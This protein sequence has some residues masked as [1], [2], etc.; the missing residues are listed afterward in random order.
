MNSVLSKVNGKGLPKLIYIMGTGRSGTTILEV[1]L[2]NND[3]ISGVG[4]VDHIFKDGYINDVDCSCG[5]TVSNCSLWK[6]VREDC[7]WNDVDVKALDRLF[8]SFSSHV[9]FPLVALGLISEKKINKYMRVNEGLFMAVSFRANAQVIVDSSKYAGRGLALYRCFPSN[10]KV[11]CITRSPSGLISA[12]QRTDTEEQRP[13][14]VLGTF[15]YYTYTMTCFRIVGFLLRNDILFVRYEDLSEYP[16]ET[17]QVI[18]D[19]ANLDLSVAMEI[20]R[21]NKSLSIHHIVTGNRLRRK[22]KVRFA[23]KQNRSYRFNNP[24][25]NI[26][27]MLMLCY[28]NMLF[29][30]VM[31]VEDDRK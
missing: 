19:W 22:G 29:F 2:S 15:L 25:V 21:Q 23:T 11:V 31:G 7:G 24:F 14:S 9:R 20:V 18:Q 1:L 28:R 30:R 10:T 12:F 5:Q 26:V 3:G 8:K 13:K 27:S 17:M 6:G 4:E 16:I